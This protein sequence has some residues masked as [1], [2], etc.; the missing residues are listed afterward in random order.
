MNFSSQENI[1]ILSPGDIAFRKL[2]QECMATGQD[3]WV[4]ATEHGIDLGSEQYGP[5]LNK[6]FR[7]RSRTY[8]ELQFLSKMMA[9][10][11]DC[12]KGACGTGFCKTAINYKLEKL[13]GNGSNSTAS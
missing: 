7:E 12:C 2:V 8:E 3:P 13:Q 10:A 1:P 6:W 5:A 4:Y 11:K 9:E